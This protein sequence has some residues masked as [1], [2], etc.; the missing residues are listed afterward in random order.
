M[1]KLWGGR[2]EKGTSSLV[3]DFHSSIA[4]DKRLYKEDI[5]GSMA[6]ATMLGAQGII[7]A[8]EAVQLVDGLAG[9]HK[10]IEEGNVDFDISA[11]DIHMNVEKLLIERIGAVG[12]KLHTARSR[13][14]QV[15]LDLR[16]YLR[17]EIK[18]VQALLINLLKVLVSLCDEHVHTIMPGY[19]HVQRALPVIVQFFPRYHHL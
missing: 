8:E 17:G 7:S 4:F 18:E 11:E 14:D 10:D 2:F 13:N 16:L 1:K 19:T 15:A 12:K 3:E 5:H 6:H 9:I